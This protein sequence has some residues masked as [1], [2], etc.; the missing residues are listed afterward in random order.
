METTT[1]KLGQAV[2]Y[3]DRADRRKLA[4]VLAT[5]DTMPEVDEER[6]REAGSRPRA[7][8]RAVL[9]RRPVR[10]VRRTGRCGPSTFTVI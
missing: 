7:P 2:E 5:P 10:Q 1:L 4:L 8:A 6:H 9:H 3:R